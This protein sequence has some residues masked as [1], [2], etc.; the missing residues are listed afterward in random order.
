MFDKLFSPFTVKDMELKNRVVLPA[1]GT[2]LSGK[3]R[4][5][6]PT[7]IDYH[8]A[9]V[10]G[11]SGLNIVEVCSVHTPSAPKGF[12]S[13]SKDTY[14]PRLQRLTK[15]IHEAGG[16]AG[17][18]LWQ[19]SLAVG[20]DP[21]AQ[22]LLASDMEMSPGVT[23]PG[24]SGEMIEEIVESYGEAA[25]RAVKAGFDCVEFHCAH[26]YLP[27]S[28]LSGGINHRT[29]EYGGSFENR[30]K[31]PLACIRAIRANIPEGM[32][33]FMRIDA[34]DDYLENG[35]TIEDVITF[36]KLAKE[37]GVDVLDISR[38]NILTAC[39]K[40]ACDIGETGFGWII[41]SLKCPNWPD[42]ICCGL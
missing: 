35:L 28:F 41:V 11:G 14:I 26:N 38:G 20:M 36:C 30:A 39:K 6:T 4:D 25:G 15:A 37:A 8:V 21:D 17:L 27:H 24:I 40:R 16:K 5:V 3:T 31:F 29:D 1:M 13:I 18:Q 23:L 10:R 9:R 33:L 34:H 22:I 32:P 7:L 42:V 12:L 19:G 2:K